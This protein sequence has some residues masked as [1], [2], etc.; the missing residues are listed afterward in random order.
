MFGG[1]ELA[2]GL[3]PDKGLLDVPKL[4]QAAAGPGLWSVGGTGG[5]QSHV[6]DE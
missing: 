5:V 3:L 1:W 6:L 2:A 4:V